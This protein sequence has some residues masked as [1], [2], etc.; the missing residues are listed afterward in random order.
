MYAY[1]SYTLLLILSLALHLVDEARMAA[2]IVFIVTGL[3]FAMGFILSVTGTTSLKRRYEWERS[4]GTH[5][6]SGFRGLATLLSDFFIMPVALATAT[7]ALV[8][9][10]EHGTEDQTAAFAYGVAI[11]SATIGNAVCNLLHITE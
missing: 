8:R 11:A 4:D 2:S 5:R 1:F 7:L 3:H 10:D 9:I 6:S